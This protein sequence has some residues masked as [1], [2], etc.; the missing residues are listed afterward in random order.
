FEVI[1]FELWMIWRLWPLLV[2]YVGLTT[3]FPNKSRRHDNQWHHHWDEHGQEEQ[4]FR[5]GPFHVQVGKIKRRHANWSAEPTELRNAIGEYDFDYTKAFIP[6]EEI[7]VKL[8]GWIG[9]IKI[10]VPRDVEFAAK[11][12]ALVGDIYIAG[13]NKDGISLALTYKTPGYDEA[14]RKLTFDIDYRI[15]DLRIDYV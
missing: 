15:L 8:S 5:T 3:L 10:L 4:E 13:Q 14:V 6:E 7:P 12:R 11:A 9:D 2:V 1:T